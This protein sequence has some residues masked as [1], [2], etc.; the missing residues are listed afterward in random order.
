[1]EAQ[2]QLMFSNLI[3][4][5]YRIPTMVFTLTTGQEKGYNKG[6]NPIL[7]VHGN[8]LKSQHQRAR[9]QR[10]ANTSNQSREPKKDRQVNYI[11]SLFHFFMF[12]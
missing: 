6:A 2:K 3:R 4:A 5:N 10:K 12:S 7:K 1:M 11:Q 8:Q 9:S